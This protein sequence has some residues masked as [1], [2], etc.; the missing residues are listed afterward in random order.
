MEIAALV[1]LLM[2]LTD[3]AAKI[4]PLVAQHL[5]GTPVTPEQVKTAQQETAALLSELNAMVP[6]DTPGND[7]A[8]GEA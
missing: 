2:A 7:G 5:A 1:S 4:A 3:S 8:V 6:S